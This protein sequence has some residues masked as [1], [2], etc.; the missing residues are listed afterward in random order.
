MCVCVCVCVCVCY[1]VCKVTL[2]SILVVTQIP[3]VNWM[4]R[5]LFF[6]C[7]VFGWGGGGVVRGRGG[8]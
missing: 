5:F 2:A 7:P 4:K 8:A 1:V 6:S 3:S